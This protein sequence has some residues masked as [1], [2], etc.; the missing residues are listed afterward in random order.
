MGGRSGDAGRGPRILKVGRTML[1]LAGVAGCATRGDMESLMAEHQEIRQRQDD[2]NAR[3]NDLAR[4]LETLMQGIRADF[5]ADLGQV[6]QQMNSV[7]SALRGTES[8]IEQ[9]R[10]YQPTPQP[11]PSSQDSAAMTVDPIGLYN[12]AITD[13][14]QGRLDMARQGFAEYLRVFP[15]GPSASDSQ[16][17]LGIIAYDQGEYGQAVDLLRRVPDQYPESSKAPL[18][19]RKIGDAYRAMG[20]SGSARDV[21]QELIDRYPN[22]SEADAARRE[23]GN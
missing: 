20:D 21:Y 10:R 9:L 8:R 11:V 5:Q 6:I 13:Y 17:W 4:N 2:L 3:M 14:Q 15:D 23:I 22:S 18:A 7:E 16:Y 1:L 19:L 12:G